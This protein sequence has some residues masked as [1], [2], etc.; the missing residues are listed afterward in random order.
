MLS[1]K[2]RRAKRNARKA[3]T[4]VTSLQSRVADLAEADISVPASLKTLLDIH[5]NTFSD[6]PTISKITCQMYEC[7]EENWQNSLCVLSC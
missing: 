3:I 4:E 5:S 2:L 6:R 7:A 1:T